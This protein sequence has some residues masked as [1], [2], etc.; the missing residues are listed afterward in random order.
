[1]TIWSANSSRA[2]RAWVR[3]C[4]R[5]VWAERN[6]KK[7]VQVHGFSLVDNLIAGAAGAI[8]LAACCLTVG[9]LS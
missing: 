2:D 7:L 1:M 4:S 9:A 6:G 8:V 5:P 3:V